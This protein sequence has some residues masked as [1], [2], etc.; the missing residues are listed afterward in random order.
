MLGACRLCVTYQTVSK[1]KVSSRTYANRLN[2]QWPVCPFE[3]R[4]TCRDLKCPFQMNQD[5]N[6]S[7]MEVLQDLQNLAKRCWLKPSCLTLSS[8]AFII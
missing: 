6:M 4:G 1:L 8:L 5:V 3:L 7:N 2:P